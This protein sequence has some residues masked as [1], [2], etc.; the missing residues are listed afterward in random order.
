MRG[1]E[2]VEDLE[3]LKEL[4]KGREKLEELAT[5]ANIV[6]LSIAIM[7]AILVAILYI[8]IS[9]EKGY[10]N[11]GGESKMQCVCGSGDI[12]TISAKCSDMFECYA[13]DGREHEGYVSNDIVNIG[14]GD[15]IEFSVCLD[16]N[17]VQHDVKP[18][19]GERK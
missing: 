6:A 19:G 15:Y 11:L 17:R 16:C 1:E 5:M 18:Q 4:V 8:V 10:E 12:V 13:W 2:I 9:T 14:S 3:K 7:V